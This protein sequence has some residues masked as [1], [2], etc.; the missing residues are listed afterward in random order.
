MLL[1]RFHSTAPRHATAQASS[2][3]WLARAH[4]ISAGDAK[5]SERIERVLARCAAHIDSRGHSIDEVAA[6]RWDGD[7]YDLPREP[8]GAGTGARTAAFERI[9][10]RYFDDEFPGDPPDDLVH[11]TCTGYSSP[12]GAQ[13]V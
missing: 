3:H 1:T 12:S 2:L 10:D 11:V 8:H 5:L 13:W 6:G 9:V 4:A 7:L